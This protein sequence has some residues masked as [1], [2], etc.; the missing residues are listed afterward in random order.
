MDVRSSDYYTFQWEIIIVGEDS[1]NLI[2]Y[3][4]VPVLTLSFSKILPVPQDL[5]KTEAG[6]EEFWWKKENWGDTFPHFSDRFLYDKK[7]KMYSGFIYTNDKVDKIFTALSKKLPK[8]VLWV[9]KTYMNTDAK[10]KKRVM[11]TY[12]Y[13]YKN[14][15]SKIKSNVTDEIE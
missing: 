5:E 2:D 14:G 7:N 12:N 15:K 6:D 1:Y 10:T 13:E 8:S 11:V 3:L 9:S 4:N